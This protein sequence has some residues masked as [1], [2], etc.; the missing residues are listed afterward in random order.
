MRSLN[1]TLDEDVVEMDLDP[2]VLLSNL[3]RETHLLSQTGIESLNHSHALNAY[4]RVHQGQYES[5]GD[6]KKLW[7]PSNIQ[8]FQRKELEYLIL[9]NRSMVTI[10]NGNAI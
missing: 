5:L 8:I 4:N 7:K 3:I 9:W 6:Y 10:T 2:F 1:D